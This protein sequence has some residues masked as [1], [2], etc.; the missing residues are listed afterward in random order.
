MAGHIVEAQ[1]CVFQDPRRRLS[2]WSAVGEL[3]RILFA[4]WGIGVALPLFVVSLAFRD[5][6]LS[7]ITFD[8]GE[9]AVARLIRFRFCN[10]GG[11]TL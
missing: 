11:C 4:A 7:A 8:W 2:R 1:E 9:N 10:E 6:L 5:R 3:P